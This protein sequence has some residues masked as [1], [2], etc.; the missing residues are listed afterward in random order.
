MKKVN[1]SDEQAVAQAQAKEKRQR[2][3]EIADVDKLLN[4][5]WGRRIV[6]R[7]LETSGMRRSSFQQGSN[8]NTFFNEGMRNVGL[9][10]LSEA[11]EAD[12]KNVL[13]PMMETENKPKR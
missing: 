8:S 9:W 6:W 10:L 3:K 5:D 7:I 2:S 11:E 13:L 4:E 12:E 1:A